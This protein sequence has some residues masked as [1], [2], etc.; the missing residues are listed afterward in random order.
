MIP[1]DYN[2]EERKWEAITKI[3][4]SVIVVAIILV[5]F[6]Y[7]PTIKENKFTNIGIISHTNSDAISTI[8]NNKRFTNNFSFECT[9]E[10][11]NF[12]DYEVKD[13]IYHS[14]FR[15]WFEK[16]DKNEWL[17]NNKIK[18]TKTKEETLNYLNNCFNKYTNELKKYE[19]TKE[20]KDK[21]HIEIEESWK[22]KSI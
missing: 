13:N 15:N 11:Q 17:V 12:L 16:N 8:N 6:K 21:K 10:E 3:I 19:K 9:D 20:I 18:E 1:G 4:G 5:I 7:V 22:I 14:N 2:P